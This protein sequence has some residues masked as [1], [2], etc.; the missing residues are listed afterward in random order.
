MTA[1]EMYFKIHELYSDYSYGLFTKE[2]LRNKIEELCSEVLE[3]DKVYELELEVKSLQKDVKKHYEEKV[4]LEKQLIAATKQL[5]QLN[6]EID[7]L[8]GV[9]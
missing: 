7:R 1:E 4:E 5:V 9:N 3:E 8:K 2:T 6:K